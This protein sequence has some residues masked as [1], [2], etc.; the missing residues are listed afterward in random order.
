MKFG[1]SWLD[2]LLE[3]SQK[4]RKQLKA[5]LLTGIR[6]AKA[7]WTN[8]KNPEERKIKSKNPESK[9]LANWLESDDFDFIGF[10]PSIMYVKETGPKPDLDAIWHHDFAVPSLLYKHKDLP[11]LIISNPGLDFNNSVVKSID[12][13]QYNAVIYGI[14][15]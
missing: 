12:A 1:L 4:R 13:N 9:K 10:T 14:T 11:F 15:G 6:E 8:H 5:A 2:D 3:S 7:E